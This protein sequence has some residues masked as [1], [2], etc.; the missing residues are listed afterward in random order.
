[1]HKAFKA[2]TNNFPRECILNSLIK[3][4]YSIDSISNLVGFIG[5]LLDCMLIGK[6]DFKLMSKLGNVAF[7][8][9]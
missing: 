4:Y 9:W 8:K 2:M 3:H 1:M 5:N 6:S 7:S